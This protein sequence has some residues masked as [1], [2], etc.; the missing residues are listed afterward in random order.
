[1]LLVKLVGEACWCTTWLECR[2]MLGLY[3]CRKCVTV[4]TVHERPVLR[5][6]RLDSAERAVQRGVFVL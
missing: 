3:V 6:P 2:L 4:Q 1:M 5:R